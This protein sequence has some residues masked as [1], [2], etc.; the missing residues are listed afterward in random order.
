MSQSQL[1]VL[2]LALSC[3]CLDQSLP[4]GPASSEGDPESSAGGGGGLLALAPLSGLLLCR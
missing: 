3:Q 2:F 4:L 1:L